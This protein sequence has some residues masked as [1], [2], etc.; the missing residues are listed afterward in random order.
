MMNFVLYI[1]QPIDGPN[2]GLAPGPWQ[3]VVQPGE[4][5]KDKVQT[6]E[7]PHTAS[8]KVCHNCTGA[9]LNRCDKCLGRGQVIK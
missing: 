4:M 8:V 6:V 7:V 1:G 5:F 9:G 3:I 2:N